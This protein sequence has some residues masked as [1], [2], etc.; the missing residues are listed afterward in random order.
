MFVCVLAFSLND[1]QSRQIV[2]DFI[3]FFQLL[4]PFV[5]LTKLE[6]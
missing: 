4:Y 5:L 3:G 6:I 2:S 1:M